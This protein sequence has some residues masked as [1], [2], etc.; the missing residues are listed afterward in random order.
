MSRALG[1]LRSGVLGPTAESCVGVVG[2]VDQFNLILILMR[3]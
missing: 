3:G 2:K 1:V